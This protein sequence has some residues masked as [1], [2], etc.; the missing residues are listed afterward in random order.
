VAGLPAA[1]AAAAP[2]L[3]G[4]HASGGHRSRIYGAWPGV[5]PK[6]HVYADVGRSPVRLRGV[7]GAAVGFGSPIGRIGGPAVRDV[8]VGS[9]RIGHVCVGRQASVGVTPV[10]GRARIGR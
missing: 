4:I 2:A 8:A 1:G 3:F 6:P 10:G 5:P 9:A 7:L